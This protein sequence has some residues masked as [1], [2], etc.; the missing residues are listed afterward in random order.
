MDASDLY[1][2]VLT[3]VLIG[4]VLGVGLLVLDKFANTD[5]IGQTAG[6]AVNDTISAIADIP[7]TWLGLVVTITVL[8]IILTLV[9]KSF[10]VGNF[11]RQ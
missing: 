1:T 6:K 9:I 3:L 11:N 8:A 4:M 2:F 5:G 10:V 7:T